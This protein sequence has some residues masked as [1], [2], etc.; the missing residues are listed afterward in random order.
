MRSRRHATSVA[1]SHNPSQFCFRG[2][3]SIAFERRGCRP[4][5]TTEQD[6]TI[7]LGS[8]HP[9]T[10]GFISSRTTSYHVFFCALVYSAS[11]ELSCV[12]HG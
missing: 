9:D 3:G 10:T 8:D 7:R 2:A 11:L 4:I 1:G 12:T 6:R 5:R